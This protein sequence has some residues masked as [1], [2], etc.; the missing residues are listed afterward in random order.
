LELAQPVDPVANSTGVDA[1]DLPEIDHRGARRNLVDEITELVVFVDDA[2]EFDVA[3]V[4][5]V[6]DGCL[7]LLAHK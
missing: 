6:L 5:T 3:D 4:T 2:A 1:F 7:E